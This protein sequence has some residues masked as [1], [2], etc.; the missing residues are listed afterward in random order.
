[1]LSVRRRR[2]S[3]T[4]RLDE[5]QLITTPSSGVRLA[6]VEGLRAVAASSIVVVHVWGFG[7]GHALGSGRIA[8]AFS[9]LSVGV[10]LFF[11]LSGFL[12]YRPFAA[13]IARGKPHMPIRAYLRNRALRIIPAYWVILVITALVFAAAGIRD[14]SGNFGLGR[15]TDPL[16][17]FQAAFLLQ[18]YRP[19]TMVVG[20][21]PAWS[22]AVEVVFYCVLPL[23]VLAALWASR[24]AKD[25]TG[26]VLVLLGPPLLLLLV[27]LSG[28][29]AAHMLPGSPIAG[30]NAD[31]HSVIERSF[32]AQADLFTF[33][34]VVAV[35]YTE[36]VDGRIVLS[37]YWRHMAVGL[38]LLVFLPC[39]WT[40]H[41]GEQSYL[42]QNTGE[43]LGIGLLFAGII[44]PDPAA[45][46]PL[47]VIR[48]LETRPFVATGL[49]SYSLFLW[50][51][52]VIQWLEHRG[53]TFGG[54][55]G[56]PINLVIVGVVAGGLSALTYRFVELP[57]LKRKRST[58]TPER[59]AP[60][61]VTAAPER[62]EVVVAAPDPA[63][64]QSQA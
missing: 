43:A 12:L 30:Y 46:R 64:P 57:A 10:T 29:H 38:G 21:G 34:M 35:L 49:V 22:L 14:A 53:L 25:R 27:G 62:P 32:W 17:F 39:A 44:I 55:T 3:A 23:L 7:A 42:L 63:I 5:P 24:F 2:A 9:T 52:E 31:W 47:R 36:V 61:P 56:L 1:V 19:S 8:Y 28:K 48:L 37:R 50:H 18:D 26:R 33:G 58:R 4:T 15:L 6:G 40:M 54:W 41:G 13:S 59:L 60:I 11:T 45:T 20:I 16:G 51:N